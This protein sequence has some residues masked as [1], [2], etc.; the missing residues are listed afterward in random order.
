[1]NATI[2]QNRELFSL[3][4]GKYILAIMIN[5]YVKQLIDVDKLTDLKVK[6]IG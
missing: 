3:H 2:I 5:K 6:R 1:M 4:T